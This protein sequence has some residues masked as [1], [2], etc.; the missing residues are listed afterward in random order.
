MRV[1]E[2]PAFNSKVEISEYSIA[3][4]GEIASHMAGLTRLGLKCAYAGRFGDDQAR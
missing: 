2:Y 3:A 4:G 1:P